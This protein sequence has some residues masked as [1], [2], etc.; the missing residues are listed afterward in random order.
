MGHFR[1]VR[2]VLIAAVAA[3]ALLASRE[4][5]NEVDTGSAKSLLEPRVVAYC[6]EV[7]VCARLLSERRGQLS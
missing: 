3:A 1:A 7:V 4:P 5:L 6:S 2:E